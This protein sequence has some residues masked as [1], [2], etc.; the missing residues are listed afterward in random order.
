VIRITEAPNTTIIM[1]LLPDTGTGVDSGA[2]GCA[3]TTGA[4]G[5]WVRDLD[6]DGKTVATLENMTVHSGDTVQVTVPVQ[7]KATGERNFYIP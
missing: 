5:C 4:T 1:S 2:T 6:F 3:A 7:L